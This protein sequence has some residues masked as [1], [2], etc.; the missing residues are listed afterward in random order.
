MQK[1]SKDNT[2][3]VLNRDRGDS[4]IILGKHNDLVAAN[5]INKQIIFAANEEAIISVLRSIDPVIAKNLFG[6]IFTEE[7][8]KG[9]YSLA[10]Y[11]SFNVF[12]KAFFPKDT[13]VTDSDIRSNRR[14]F[15]I[16]NMDTIFGALSESDQI[17]N[18]SVSTLYWDEFCHKVFN[19]DT[20]SIKNIAEDIANGNFSK[21][22]QHPEL[23]SL[24]AKCKFV[25][26][27]LNRID[28]NHRNQIRTYIAV[29][30]RKS[31]EL[32]ILD[33]RIAQLKNNEDIAS[34]TSIS[35][36][37]LTVDDSYLSKN[38]KDR[39]QIIKDALIEQGISEEDI[40]DYK[41]IVFTYLDA[42]IV[43]DKLNSIALE[44]DSLK[45]IKDNHQ[46]DAVK[47][48]ESKVI[49]TCN[50]IRSHNYF[51]K[52]GLINTNTELAKYKNQHD[53]LDYLRQLF[54]DRKNNFDYYLSKLNEA[55]RNAAQEEYKAL[56]KKLVNYIKAKYPNINEDLIK[57][58][59]H[60]EEFDENT[61][62]NILSKNAEY[63]AAVVAIFDSINKFNTELATNNKEA[64]K[65]INTES[66]N[67]PSSVEQRV[68]MLMLRLHGINPNKVKI[69][70]MI[71]FIIL[72]QDS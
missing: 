59:E 25:Q 9:K 13:D 48:Y 53:A 17:D 6:S 63:K 7:S 4:S 66:I 20:V 70:L 14:D 23:L 43:R 21:F 71:V 44:E 42:L 8:N 30:T 41:N 60:P 3:V 34:N 64:W 40:K 47:S 49:D 11:S 68:G 65:F 69:L 10:N 32:A 27:E 45:D 16:Q 55:K 31:N 22:A 36:L 28:E 15:I 37:A 24:F 51:N 19:D 46:S 50:H 72:L 62:Q 39:K 26:S 1:Y 33:S 35:N 58:I 56:T 57:L 12:W 38:W 52:W 61:I 29:E 5:L 54:E 67:V 18:N 2:V